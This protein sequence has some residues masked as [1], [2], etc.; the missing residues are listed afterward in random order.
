MKLDASSIFGVLEEHKDFKY[1]V[2][3][4]ETI[5]ETDIEEA[6]A[7]LMSDEDPMRYIHMNYCI[8]LSMLMQWLL[9]QACK[10]L[11]HLMTPE[12]FVVHQ[13]RMPS[14]Y[15]ENYLRFQQHFSLK[16]LITKH[17]SSLQK[18]G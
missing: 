9:R 14:V 6:M 5:V 16:D 3:I 10:R 4:D 13:E 2:P 11:M 1:A 7:I 12:A 17:F 15:I 18:I 8:V